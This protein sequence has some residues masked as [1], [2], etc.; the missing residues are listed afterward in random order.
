LTALTALWAVNFS[1]STMPPTP[2]MTQDAGVAP[3]RLSRQGSGGGG[4]AR[5]ILAGLMSNQLSEPSGS[6]GPS[7]RRGRAGTV[8]TAVANTQTATTMTKMQ[9]E[10][11]EL[12]RL[13]EEV[14]YLRE[15][16]VEQAQQL[17]MAGVRTHVCLPRPTFV[18]TIMC[19]WLPLGGVPRGGLSRRLPDASAPHAER[20]Q[21]AEGG[22]FT[23]AG[24]RAQG[25]SL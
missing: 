14:E 9:K 4:S 16:R 1:L 22:R 13:K 15:Q 5:S 18:R 10:K 12:E 25:R 19:G 20:I 7:K 3:S 2:L 11:H 6:G 17:R 21:Q 23:G 8:P 24:S